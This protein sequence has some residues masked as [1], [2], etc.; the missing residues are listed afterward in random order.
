MADNGI[1]AVETAWIPLPS[2]IK[3][4]ARL[5]LPA[6]AHNH[7][8]PAV[9]EF[10]PYRR[11]DNTAPRDES[12]YPGFA[13]AGIAGVRVDLQGSGDSDG[14]FDDEYSNQELSDAEAVIAWIA[15]Q[16][17]CNGAVGM[18]GISWGG[19]NALQVAARKPPA[20]KAIISIASSVD[21][22]ADDIHY[23]GG[24]HLSAQLYWS[25]TMLGYIT[26]PPDAAVVGDRWRTLWLDRLQAAEPLIHQW[27]AH[28][29]RDAF[30]QHGSVCEDFARFDVPALV[31]AGWADGYR[32][33]PW[34]ALGGMP[35]CV[36]A[37]TGPWIHKYPH[38]AWPRPRVDFVN[39]AIEWWRAWLSDGSGASINDWPAHRLFISENVTPGGRREDEPGRWVA[40]DPE[41]QSVAT[42]HLHGDGVLSQAPAEAAIV[43]IATRQDCGAYG[44]EFFTVNPEW[45]L[46]ADQTAD[47]ALSVCFE[48]AVLAAPVEVIGRPK[49]RGKIR[50]NQTSGQLIA[51]LVDVRPDGRAH[52]VSMGV[53]NLCHT[54]SHSAPEALEPGQWLDVELELDVTGYRFLA[55]HKLRL[56]LSTSYFPLV[57]PPPM[58]TELDID[59]GE[60]VFELPSAASHDITI[61][62]PDD[63]DPLPHYP[64][65]SPPAGGRNIRSD[66]GRTIIETFD[67]TGTLQH[68]DNG[69]VW[70]ENKRSIWSIAPEDPGS[71]AGREEFTLMRRRNGVTCI[72]IVESEL[73]ADPDNWRIK[74][75][76]SATENGV[77]IFKRDWQQA[78]PRHLM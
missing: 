64:N 27:L 39:M 10:L 75:R 13:R 12:T 14:L 16:P 72:C 21:R 66:N 8:A 37:L 54:N 56:A 43:R 51:R 24:C 41:A 76:F 65:S 57:L 62:A 61:S 3:L 5:W 44:G 74:S 29:T 25:T 42:W 31:I 26:R 73:Q 28:Q 63:P 71:L 36:R 45:D 46:P 38:F 68:P 33:T 4:A 17:W 15:D 34:K 48:T 67:D 6:D 47:D 9:L 20:L 2:G 59:L 40:I 77:E 55:G 58:K 60:S 70:R 50:S 53:L 1:E 35:N 32:N 49:L 18:M 30:W 78:I 7:P 19:F 69:M 22:F 11:R 23:R 52:R